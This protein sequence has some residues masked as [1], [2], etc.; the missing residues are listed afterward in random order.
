MTSLLDFAKRQRCVPSVRKRGMTGNGSSG[1][2][3]FFVVTNTTWVSTK[4][5]LVNEAMAAATARERHH[6]TSMEGVGQVLFFSSPL[7]AFAATIPH[8][9]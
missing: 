1:L 8:P 7:P 5:C 3:F 6:R 9:L 4:L 2:G